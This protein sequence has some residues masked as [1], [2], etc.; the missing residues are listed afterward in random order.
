MSANA[1][2]PAGGAPSPEPGHGGLNPLDNVLGP[3]FAGIGGDAGA[4]VRCPPGTLDLSCLQTYKIDAQVYARCGG[5]GMLGGA[6]ARLH[7]TL[8][9]APAPATAE[10]GRK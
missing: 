3:A 5:R 7:G 1:T 8:G 2:P 9:C 4:G 10:R 6:A